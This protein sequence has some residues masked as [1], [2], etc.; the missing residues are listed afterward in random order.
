MQNSSVSQLSNRADS[1]GCHR[2]M[3][4]EE[5]YSRAFVLKMEERHK[6]EREQDRIKIASL[7]AYVEKIHG[8]FNKNKQLM[9]MLI[10]KVEADQRLIEQANELRQ[11]MTQTLSTIKEDRAV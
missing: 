4:R 6:R 10:N 5:N 9:Q 7:E 3:P 8:E 11:S 2:H 1:D